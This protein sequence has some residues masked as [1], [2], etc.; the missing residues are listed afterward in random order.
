M[1]RFKT[2]P[3]RHQLECLNRFGRSEY[4]ALL[5]D[6][7]TGKTFIIINNIADLWSC[8][9]LDSVLVFA[10][11][12]VHTNWTDREIP[13]H[14]PDWVRSEACSWSSTMNKKEKVIFERVVSGNAEGS[15]RIFTMNWEALGTKRAFDAA[16]KFCKTAGA[17]MIVC[18]ESHNVKNPSAARTKALMKLRK[19]SKWRRIMSGT[20]IA[21]A[22]F[23][24]FSQFS[25]LDDH[26]LRTTSYFA[27]KAEYADMIP[28]E[29]RMMQNLMRAKGL[30]RAPQ[31]V[32]RGVD[33]RPRYKNLE[34]LN[35]LIAPH[36]F[37]VLK[38]DCLDLPEK[39]YKTVLFDLTNEQR[40]IYD[41]V[42]EEGRLMLNGEDTPINRLT[43]LGK[44]SQI[45]SGYYLHPD[46]Q[47]PVRIEGGTPKMELLIDRVNEIVS[48]QDRKVIIWARYHV[49]I[50]D[51]VQALKANGFTDEHV[52]QYHGGIGKAERSEAIDRFERGEARIFVGQQQAGGTGITLVAASFVIY[53][54]NTFSLTD[55]LQSEDRAHRIGQTE[56]VTYIN[57]VAKGTVD[58][59]ISSALE[60]KKNIAEITLAF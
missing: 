3:Y 13:K 49:E 12:G 37:R 4:F 53:F 34:K 43:V 5:A 2:K 1:E 39:I 44:L 48:E 59:A 38:K 27:F 23:D 51:I 35:S 14:M 17:L 6:M 56:A 10:P 55:R 28:Q 20:P 31:I 57:L 58:V 18:D 15:L 7:G 26:I 32:S 46:A 36:S 8:G 22:P 45:T 16:E 50:S 33:G 29:S 52:V 21:N 11:N 25:F 47:S 42:Q 60:A 40:A 24:A 9:E 54:S 41:R 30:R 19:H